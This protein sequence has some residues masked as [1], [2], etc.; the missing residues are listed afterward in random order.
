MVIREVIV[1]TL[2]KII[3]FIYLALV[4]AVLGLHRCPGFSRRWGARLLPSCA[5]ASQGGRLLLEQ[6]TGLLGHMHARSL[7]FLELRL[8]SYDAGA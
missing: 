3:V 7:Q 6:S 2:L 1:L 5:Q 4:W 8:I